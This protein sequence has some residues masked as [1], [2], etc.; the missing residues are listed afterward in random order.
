M[1]KIKRFVKKHLSLCLTLMFSF[2]AT[3]IYGSISMHGNVWYDEAYQLI[4]NE[5][6][7][8]NII[9]FVA[10]DFH[11]PFYAV[12]LKM[13]TTIIGVSPFIARMFSLS[14]VVA[15]FIIC[16]YKVKDL[17]NIKVSIILASLLLSF[18]GAYY[19][20]IEIRPYSWPMFLT[21]AA[22]IE[23]LSIIKN[24]DKKSWILYTIFSIL[25]LYGHNIAMIY[26]FWNNVV[27]L[28]YLIV[29]KRKLVKY[30][31]LS[32]LIQFIFYLP[33]L[34]VLKD[35]YTGLENKF[36][37]QSPE[38]LP[39]LR[40]F[41]KL[42]S[43]SIVVSII[44]IILI[45]VG[46]VYLIIKKEYKKNILIVF[47]SFL[48]TLLFC[49]L[50][51]KYKTPLLI[52]KYINTFIGGLYLVIASLISRIKSKIYLVLLFVFLGISSFINYKYE[53]PKIKEDNRI[54]LIEKFNEYDKL[55]FVH[56]TEF[57]L[58]EFRYYFPNAIH[59]YTDEIDSNLRDYELFGENVIKLNN[60]SELDNYGIDEVWTTNLDFVNNNM[61]SREYFNK[62]KVNEY[63]EFLNNYE[64]GRHYL[65]RLNR[66]N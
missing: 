52:V 39:F 58:G 66:K 28:I 54:K 19:F 57:A 59:F 56:Y 25:A 44:L 2:I 42:F 21:F 24:N 11:V 10:R 16:F 29:K 36:W 9:T 6:S 61:E 3:I 32:F 45:I 4:L 17:F 55:Y 8:S 33:W 14:A 63:Y 40:D 18:S 62:W 64:F 60:I 30:E 13:I 7:L 26:I 35:Q 41:L 15:C 37:I 49:Y 23:M 12:G 20:S 1:K 34:N 38:I 31:L 22:T 50:V 53:I 5:N 47:F 51:S 65:K 46:I 43:N 27:F 48:T